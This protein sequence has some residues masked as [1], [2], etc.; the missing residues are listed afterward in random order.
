MAALDINV[1]EQTDAKLLDNETRGN[2][3]T[4]IMDDIKAVVVEGK[5]DEYVE[6]Y[7]SWC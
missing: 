5:E 7:G 3:Y 6:H 1:E 4:A 2:G